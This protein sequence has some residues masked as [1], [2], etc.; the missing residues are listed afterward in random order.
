M[1]VEYGLCG[2]SQPA[3]G[4]TRRSIIAESFRA[5]TGNLRRGDSDSPN[6]W[7]AEPAAPLRVPYLGCVPASLPLSGLARTPQLAGL[8]WYALHPAP[9]HAWTLVAR[10]PAYG[11]RRMCP[12]RLKRQETEE[13]PGTRSCGFRFCCSARESSRC[14][15]RAR[16]PSGCCARQE[17]QRRTRGQSAPRAAEGPTPLRAL[18][19]PPANRAPTCPGI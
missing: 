15:W 2:R 4:G 13:D 6:S 7:P 5:L 9:P 17:P 12:P 11:S 8:A 16:I 10:A 19:G 14:G 18:R 3:R 1:T